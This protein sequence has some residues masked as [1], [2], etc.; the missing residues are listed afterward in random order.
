MAGTREVTDDV[1]YDLVSIQYHALQAVESYRRYL[2][3]ARNPDLGAVTEFIRL[4]R[5]QDLERA[6]RCHDLLGELTVASGKHATT[7]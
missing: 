6:R 5:D 1:V 2:D 3:D 4:C 7:A